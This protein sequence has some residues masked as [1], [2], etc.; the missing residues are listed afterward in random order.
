MGQTC[1]WGSQVLKYKFIVSLFKAIM[2]F[3]MF[4]FVAYVLI[5]GPT[6]SCSVHNNNQ[7]NNR[8][9][10][11]NFFR[12]SIRLNKD[13]TVNLAIGPDGTCRREPTPDYM[14][15]IPNFK[16]G[17][18]QPSLPM[19][20]DKLKRS[21]PSL[22]QT[23]GCKDSIC[24]EHLSMTDRSHYCSCLDIVLGANIVPQPSR[25]KFIHGKYRDPVAL[26]SLPGSGNTW[27][28]GMLES[29]TGICTGAIYCDISLRSHG[30]TGESVREGSVLVVKTHKVKPTWTESDDRDFPKEMN[31]ETQFGSAVFV[32]R[33]P[34]NALVSE[35][36]RIVANNLTIRTIN[37]NSHTEKA[38]KEWFGENKLWSDFVVKQVN[39]WKIM[40][41]NWLMNNEDHPVLVVKYESLVNDSFTQS[42]RILDFLNVSYS[43]IHI[44]K[45]LNNGTHGFQRKHSDDFDH[46]TPS[47]RSYVQS[48]VIQ[49]IKLLQERGLDD[50]IDIRDYL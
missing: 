10:E 13:S 38:G 18:K 12:K 34:Q 23:T 14:K 24:S 32:I 26:V 3:S 4:L 8:I 11:V 27:I 9:R 19:R 35:W 21:T 20:Q 1:V 36:N 2:L 39:R 50:V 22:I 46:F 6:T 41:K 7:P 25:C 47:Q 43:P 49:T 17:P 29:L 33:N 28:R 30:F 42:K 16:Q 48:V 37:L 40:L 5:V 44:K 15:L 45:K 31:M